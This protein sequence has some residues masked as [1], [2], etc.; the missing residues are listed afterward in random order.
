MTTILIRDYTQNTYM[1][2]DGFPH[3]IFRN[4][5]LLKIIY[6]NTSV[7][8]IANNDNEILQ[9]NLMFAN[10]KTRDLKTSNLLFDINFKT[11]EGYLYLNEDKYYFSDKTN[12]Y[13]EYINKTGVK[14][15]KNIKYNFR[16]IFELDSNQ[17]TE[18]LIKEIKNFNV[19][20][21][22]ILNNCNVI[23]KIF[24]LN[25][26]IV[27]I[28]PYTNVLKSTIQEINKTMLEIVENKIN[29]IQYELYNLGICITILDLNDF[30]WDCLSDIFFI[31]FDKLA[32]I[33]K[34]A[35]GTIENGFDKF[36]LKHDEPISN[37]DFIKLKEF[38]NV[39]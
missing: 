8:Y 3:I 17:P 29:Q 1:G 15:Y 19:I 22:L 33:D 31:G 34:L 36:T 30:Y 39:D 6:I 35:F 10:S 28:E 11:V 14:I 27:K 7:F 12:L 5:Y 18:L 16:T 20:Q 24:Y 26:Y 23:P 32:F 37:D 21:H 13:I 38:E 9:N 25:S 2:N 4:E